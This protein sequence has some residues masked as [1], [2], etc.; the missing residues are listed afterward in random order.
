MKFMHLSDVRLGLHSESGRRWGEERLLEVNS[1]L[2]KA[3]RLAQE[4][5][6][7]LVL[8][9]GGLFA[10]RPITT[11]LDEA[12][13]IFREYPGISFVITAG[14]SDRIR[15][16]SPILSYRFAQNVHYVLSGSP[17]KIELPNL[18]TAVYARSVTENQISAEELISACENDATDFI[19]IAL[20]YEAGL[21][22]AR[23][24][25][26]SGFSYVALGGRG[27]HLEV[28][29]DKAF[30][31]GGLEPEGMTDQGEHGL[32]I[33]EIADA[34]GSLSGI[35]FVPL[36]SASYVPL[37]VRVGTQTTPAELSSMLEKEISRRGESNIYRVRIL[38]SRL[39]D[40]EFDLES[41]RSRYRIAEF[42]DETEP[43]YDFEELFNE[44]RQDMIGYF[45]S[46]VSKN[47]EDLPEIDKKAM[48]Y[49]IDALIQ[50]EEKEK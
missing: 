9:A 44:H 39:P 45:I 11:E 31:P 38:G 6:V 1:T 18:R 12:N 10:H 42:I 3:C 34:T 47:R 36:A 4:E 14:D 41:L 17:E 49:G 27:S 43:Q 32:F 15:S 29:K 22:K 28:I 30:Y 2:K 46:S 16:S 48:F 35:R 8:I 7:D 20:C 50:T 25:K 19:K 13:R 33:G 24:F 26:C 23:D 21:E 37:L 5:R 40:T